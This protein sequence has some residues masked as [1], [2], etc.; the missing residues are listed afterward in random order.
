MSRM[1]RLRRR[2]GQSV[3][4]HDRASS[5]AARRLDEPLDAADATW[6][7][8][9]LAGCAACRSVAAA[10]E[11]DRLQLRGLRD[12]TPE[13]PRDLWARTAAGIERESAAHG[14]A[15]RTAGGRRR[16]PALGILA[17]VAVIAVVI[18][19]TALSGGFLNGQPGNAIVQPTLPPVAVVPSA[20][21]P[22]P[23]PI[24]VGAGSVGWVGTDPDG[25]FA[26]NVTKVSEVCPAERQPD[27]A[28]VKDGGLQAGRDADPAEVHLEIAR[29]Q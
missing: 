24:A 1:H 10:Y 2:A 28:P 6:L 26:Y 14:G 15:R 8:D 3:V 27:C 13:P 18:G 22:G 21:T 7:A 20:T 16:G 5:L 4:V 11:A 9:H 23:T 29:P 17:G 25:K 19:A 12:Q